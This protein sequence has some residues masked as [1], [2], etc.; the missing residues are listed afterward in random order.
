MLSVGFSLADEDTRVGSGG[1][2]PVLALTGAAKCATSLLQIAQ[3]WGFGGLSVFLPRC[4]TQSFEMRR[5]PR[6]EGVAAKRRKLRALASLATAKTTVSGH[7]KR[8]Y[9][10]QPATARKVPVNEQVA[11]Q[12][13][14]HDPTQDARRHT[15]TPRDPPAWSLKRLVG[16]V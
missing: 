2:M 7:G 16:P 3:A 1:C 8:K 6:S 10:I 4:W 15:R 5:P 12:W 11:S 9:A 13:T 14:D